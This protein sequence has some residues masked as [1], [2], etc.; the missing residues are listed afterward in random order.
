MPRKKP[1]SKSATPARTPPPTPLEQAFKDLRHPARP[2]QTVSARWLLS[3]AAISVVAAALC[4]WGVLCLLFWQ[5]SWQLLYH[6]A[7]TSTRNPDS[8]G[9][10]FDP[11][12]FA[13]N[14]SGVPQL[15]GW[16]IP[17]A[18]DALY[19]HY[20]VL[21]LHSQNGNLFNTVDDIAFL[22]SVGLNVFA[23]DYRGYGLSQPSHPS[24]AHWLEDAACA[25]TYLTQTRHMPPN[26]ILL[27]GKDLGANLALEVAA[28]HPDLAGVV[29]DQP[30]DSPMS[31][32]FNDPRAAL[33][34]AH[35]LV[36]DRYDADAAASALRIP[37]LWLQIQP[38]RIAT[39]PSANPSVA[40]QAYSRVTARKALVTLN[41]RDPALA[42]NRSAA[43]T[44]WLDDL[45]ATPARQAP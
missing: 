16:W 44:R 43:L 20:T 27:D 15:T 24:E 1:Q 12:V 34:P 7:S 31:S 23:F 25:L 10:D 30:L 18:P 5:G 32:V 13:P 33:V 45:S 8:A 37:S 42:A 41:A 38:S 14:N 9:L 39:Q 4:A 21:Y 36:R 26:A 22:H 29:L 6:P 2:P 35:L 40:P 19:A 3:A 11:I 17:A 28:A